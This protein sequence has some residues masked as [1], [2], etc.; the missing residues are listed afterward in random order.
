[1]KSF[2]F[3]RLKD[4]KL[5]PET[6]RLIAQIH[7]HKGKQTLYLQQSPEALDRLVEIAK[8]QSIES[9]NKIEGISTTSARL[10]KLVADKTTSKNR[11]EEEILGYRDA[12]ALIHKNYDLIPIT[13][14]Y[15]L[16]LHQILYS[17]TTK[18]IGGKFKTSQNYIAAVYPN[19]KKEILFTPLSP[20]ETPEAVAN[21]CDSFNRA[22]EEEEIETLLLIPAFIEDFICIHPFSDG[23][24][25][26]SRLLTTLL[27]YRSGYEVGR[28]ISIENLIEKNKDLY[29]EALR[30][31]DEGWKENKNDPL[32]F[33]KFLLRIL[34]YA[35]REFENRFELITGDENGSY[36]VVKRAIDCFIGRFTKADI[37]EKCP[38]FG[39]STI[40]LALKNLV[41]DGY[42]TRSGS[43]RSSY[44]FKTKI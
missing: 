20:I 34:L 25:R 41:Q 36:V 33:I 26:M 13:P 17:R 12:L 44:Y 9:S 6:I 38:F 29:Y 16:Q 2:D 11:D 1:M 7:E 21:L 42:I 14:N 40:E 5:D 27:L 28:Y 39:K 31:G 10:K 18:N 32:P 23:N 4:L 15:I 24:G 35:Y 19:G 22:M 43:G 8:V 37:L 3:N 30:K